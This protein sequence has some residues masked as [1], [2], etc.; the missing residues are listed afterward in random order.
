MAIL[1]KGQTFA[2]SDS[3]TSTKL[4]NLVDAAVFVTGASGSTDD[5]SLE[6]NGSGRLQVK[7]SGVIS[8]KIDNGAVTTVKIADTNVTT[9]KIADANVTTAKIADAN[10]TTAKIADASIT[11]PK[12]NGEQTG[13]APIFGARAYGAFNG[14]AT[15][16]ITPIKAGNITSITRL[17]TGLYKVIMTTPMESSSYCVVA[18]ATHQAGVTFGTNCWVV[19]DSSSEFNISTGTI[20]TGN[21]YNSININFSVFA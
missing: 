13:T 4:N 18:N 7:D 21:T 6:V 19:I 1:T 14:T 5:T 8:S 12:L 2:D 17:E 10:V 16:P 15:S 20:S 3:V 9:V 11:A